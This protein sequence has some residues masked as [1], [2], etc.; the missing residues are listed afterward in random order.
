[1]QT[2]LKKSKKNNKNFFDMSENLR[3]S[4][5]KKYGKDKFVFYKYSWEIKMKI[6]Q[7]ITYIILENCISHILCILNLNKSYCFTHVQ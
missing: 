2:S 6:I 4:E 5:R 3:C 1:M 7:M